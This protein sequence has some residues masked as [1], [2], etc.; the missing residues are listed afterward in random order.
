M[1]QNPSDD[2]WYCSNCCH[3]AV[4][5]YPAVPTPLTGDI[6]CVVM[7]AHS[8]VGKRFDL[9]AYLGAYQIDILAI[10]ETFL[11]DTIHDSSIVP[12]GYVIYHRD[13]NQ[14]G[15]GVLIMVRNTFSVV[16]R[17]DLDLPYEILWIELVACSGSPLLFGVVYRP[18]SAD[19]SVL[20]QLY[21]VLN[22]L[23]S[24]R[25]NIMLCGDFN[26]PDIDWNT[27]CPTSSSQS[28]TTLCN[29]AADN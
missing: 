2:L 6:C 18:P 4:G 1:V 25:C 20:D 9:C 19:N 23:T 12:F 5:G 21:C 22:S 3:A 15:G 27:L 29:L 11:D 16:N 13:R 7:N 17:H 26:V 8:I 24:T 14:H 28:A 10:T